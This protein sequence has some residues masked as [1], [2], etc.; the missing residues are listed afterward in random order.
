[1]SRQHKLT[2]I[3]RAS[4]GYGPCVYYARQDEMT[5]EVFGQKLQQEYDIALNGD[6]VK[7]LW[8]RVNVIDPRQNDAYDYYLEHCTSPGRGRFAVWAYE[9]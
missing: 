7:A 9:V 4:D 2:G 5:V 6:A 3:F 1:M 8:L